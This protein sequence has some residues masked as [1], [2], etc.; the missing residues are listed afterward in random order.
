MCFGSEASPAIAARPVQT[1]IAKVRQI[2]QIIQ[3]LV[4]ARD[5]NHPCWRWASD[6][7]SR[8]TRAVRAES[9]YMVKQ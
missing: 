5:L 7:Q 4:S 3:I 2:T 6:F 1:M 8:R 9:S